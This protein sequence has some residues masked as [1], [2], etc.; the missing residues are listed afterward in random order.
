MLEYLDKKIKF[1]SLTIAKSRK[2]T[3]YIY[4]R[5]LF[6]TWMKEFRKGKEL[7]RPVV[8]RFTISYLTLKCLNEHKGS[9]LSLFASNKWKSNKF[10]S[11]VEVRRVQRIVLDTRDFGRVL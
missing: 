9:L 4:S 1:H 11:S 7:I 2:I 6:L 3:T 5:T 8:I 10:A